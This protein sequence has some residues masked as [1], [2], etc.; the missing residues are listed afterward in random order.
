LYWTTRHLRHGNEEDLW[1]WKLLGWNL[2]D[3]KNSNNSQLKRSYTTNIELTIGKKE[4][5][6]PI[7]YA[8]IKINPSKYK[9]SFPDLKFMWFELIVNM[10]FKEIYSV[11]QV[12]IWKIIWMYKKTVDARYWPNLINE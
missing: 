10:I 4:V 6:L 9:P 12:R 7:I 1:H 8:R 3:D 11:L 2:K 5:N